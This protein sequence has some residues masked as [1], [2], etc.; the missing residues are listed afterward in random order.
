MKKFILIVLF[1]S[2][3][4]LSGFLVNKLLNGKTIITD[5]NNISDNTDSNSNDNND[6]TSNNN[7]I[8][9]NNNNSSNQNN[10]QTN[11][12]HLI[13]NKEKASKILA[14]MS[15]DEIKANSLS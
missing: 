8:S 5:K 13:S 2:L 14:N 1:V 4:V 6:N 11:N 12:N 9:E 15:L 10:N 7:D 3:S